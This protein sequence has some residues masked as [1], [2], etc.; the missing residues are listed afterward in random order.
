VSKAIF[1]IQLE[2]FFHHAAKLVLWKVTARV[3]EVKINPALS[4]FSRLLL[5][6]PS[7]I[8]LTFLP[9]TAALAQSS[10]VVEALCRSEDELKFQLAS[11][12]TRRNELY[13]V[14]KEQSV[15]RKE[16][17]YTRIDKKFARQEILKQIS[18]LQAA[19]RELDQNAD[20]AAA[21]IDAREKATAEI[22]QEI[23]EL[24]AREEQYNTALLDVQFAI[25]RAE[26]QQKRGNNE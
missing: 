3:E 9:Q 7:I 14:I 11:V 17:I 22:K 13:R 6:A 15:D 16:A 18:Q 19:L 5:S 4:T 1:P 2:M 25:R 10:Q 12:Q 21:K 26:K 23:S 20:A 8:L 24:A